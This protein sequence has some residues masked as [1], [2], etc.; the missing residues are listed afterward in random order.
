MITES[1]AREF[2]GDPTLAVG[3]RLST[4]YGPGD[5][6][7]I[8]GVVG[9]VRDDGLD[10]PPVDIVFWPMVMEGF[11][12][13]PS[14]DALFFRRTMK[15]AVRSTRVETP[16]F[17]EEVKDLVW[18]AYPTQPVVN[19]LTM[20]EIQQDSLARSSFTLVMLGIA[21]GVALLL[22]SIGIY[23]VISYTV[24]QRT[25]EL[26]LRI[27]MGAEPGVVTGMVMRQGLVL[28]LVG[29]AVGLGGALG[30]TRLMEAVLFG[31]D[32][33]D[34]LTFALVAMVLVGVALA[35]TYVP[36]RKA[37]TV[38]PMVALRTD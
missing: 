31:V 30:T 26:G 11:W 35:S 2:W 5:W 25:R 6:R 32:P 10:Q 38:D 17:L 34:P 37:A 1:I 23:G 27:A 28:A 19:P 3:R 13:E 24:G 21:A 36:A 9:N 15:Y 33:V 22:G 20:K 29:A 14:S 8:V 12:S 18:A 16:G 7:E 4:G